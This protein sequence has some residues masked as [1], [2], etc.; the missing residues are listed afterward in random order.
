LATK[1]GITEIQSKTPQMQYLY[2][3]GTYEFT[4]LN[5][6]R[7]YIQVYRWKHITEHYWWFNTCTETLHIPAIHA[8]F[9]QCLISDLQLYRQTDNCEVTKV[10]ICHLAFIQQLQ[11]ETALTLSVRNKFFKFYSQCWICTQW[12]IKNVTFYF[13]L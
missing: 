4:L 11:T 5:K 9:R 13:W 7:E 3:E 1:S 6:Q 2:Q 12:T 10:T 8:L